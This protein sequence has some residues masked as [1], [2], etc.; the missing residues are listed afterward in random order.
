MMEIL[1][2]I[3]TEKAKRPAAL[4]FSISHHTSEKSYV[5]SEILVAVA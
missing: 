3:V 5:T 2:T 1:N 4:F